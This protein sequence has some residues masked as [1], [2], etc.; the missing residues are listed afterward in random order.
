MTRSGIE[1]RSPGP[2]VNTL[3]IMPYI[4][5]YIY[6]CTI[7]SFYRQYNS[8]TI[9]VNHSPNLQMWND[10]SVIWSP[11]SFNPLLNKKRKKRNWIVQF[12]CFDHTHPKY[13]TQWF[14][15]CIVRNGSDWAARNY[16]HLVYCIFFFILVSFHF[17]NGC[18]GGG[19]D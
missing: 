3:T 6:E 13:H 7:I 17:I 14:S 15:L 8:Q 19:G 16:V 11:L 1:P 2:S 9:L 10:G 5:I 4:Y 18:I 12:M